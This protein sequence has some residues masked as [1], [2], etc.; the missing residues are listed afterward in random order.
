M[1]LSIVEDKPDEHSEDCHCSSKG[2]EEEHQ[3]R[4]H[5]DRSYIKKMFVLVYAMVTDYDFTSMTT[6]QMMIYF[7]KP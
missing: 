5:S 7:Y 3:P 4:L 6:T 2:P 1:P